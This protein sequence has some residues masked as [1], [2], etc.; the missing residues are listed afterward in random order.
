[1]NCCILASSARISDDSTWSLPDI[2]LG[3]SPEVSQEDDGLLPAEMLLFRKRSA[4]TQPDE[5]E[6]DN[7]DE[8]TENADN[9]ELGESICNYSTYCT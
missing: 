7:I 8:H 2:D 1:M 5:D 4:P 6:V 3:P 9:I